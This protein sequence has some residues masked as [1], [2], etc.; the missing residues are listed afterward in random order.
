MKSRKMIAAALA[1][2]LSVS[3]LATTALAAAPETESG[4]ETSSQSAQ[5]GRARGQHGSKPSVA[6]PE[7]AIGKDAAKAKA[8]ADA[9][10]TADRA[11]KVTSRV[12]KLDDGTVIYKVSFTCDGQRY[13]Y[14]IHALTGEVIDKSAAAATDS[15]A[16]SRGHDQHG[17]KPS[18]AEPENAIGK[19]AAKAKALADAGV[20]QEKAGK[21]KA[22][23]SKMD[24]GTVVYKVSFTCDGQRYSYRIHAISGDVVEKTVGSASEEAAASA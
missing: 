20:T 13:S 9:G 24:D 5:T 22:H 7:N 2:I 14:Q 16:S 15:E 19:D 17:T 8:L 6:E 23:L 1:L 12:S 4:T 10:V 18:V 11:G 3:A 21:I